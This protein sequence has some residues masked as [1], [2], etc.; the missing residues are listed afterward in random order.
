MN[1]IAKDADF[2]LEDAHR[3][4]YE[5]TRA[6]A[7]GGNAPAWDDLPEDV[8]KELRQVHEQ[9]WEMQMIME[10]EVAAEEQA[11]YNLR[12]VRAI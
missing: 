9:F 8:R 5:G 4:D 1:I 6:V 3:K 12:L 11:E 2:D 10:A 7:W